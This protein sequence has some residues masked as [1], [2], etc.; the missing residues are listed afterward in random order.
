MKK[1]KLV[2][3]SH[4][5]STRTLLPTPACPA[6]SSYVASWHSTTRTRAVLVVVA[7]ARAALLLVFFAE[8]VSLNLALILV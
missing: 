4:T 6:P 2:F 3:F 5:R 1:K 7:T 8:V